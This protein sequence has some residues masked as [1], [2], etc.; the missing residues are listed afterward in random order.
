MTFVANQSTA[1]PK[2]DLIKL[3]LVA[4]GAGVADDRIVE[5][6]NAFDI[7]I[8]QD[9]PLAARVVEKMAVA[10]SPRGELFDDNT[11]H[12][13]LASRNL[14]EQF[15]SSGIETKGQKPISNKD[16]QTFAN[17]LDRTI[18]RSQKQLKRHSDSQSG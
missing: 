12:S 5:M 17:A 18:T 6:A 11:V 1:L 8:T 9:I 16:L 7:V 15:R 13:R 2:L 3:I 10:I 14:M 4:E